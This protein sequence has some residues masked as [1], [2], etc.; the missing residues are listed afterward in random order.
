MTGTEMKMQL[1]KSSCSTMMRDLSNAQNTMI[2]YLKSISAADTSD[3]D[4]I[5]EDAFDALEMP[6]SDSKDF[7]R[8]SLNNHK[9]RHYYK[10]VEDNIGRGI[11]PELKY[12]EGKY[13]SLKD[14]SCS[15]NTKCED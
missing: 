8:I 12:L 7:L 11:I 4:R 3:F 5:V 9:L 1:N 6:N 2:K 13:R 14:S 10:F 15:R